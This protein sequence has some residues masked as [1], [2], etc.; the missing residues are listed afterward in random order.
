[1]KCFRYSLIGLLFASS[2]F[3]KD[4][5][6]A[7]ST[8][9][10]PPAGLVLEIKAA[11]PPTNA[12]YRPILVTLVNKGDKPVSL[13]MPGDGSSSGW[14]TPLIGWSVIKKGE[15][16]KH[17][18]E[19]P[20]YKGPRC[21]QMNPLQKSEIFTL[22]PGQSKK[23]EWTS[24]PDQVDKP[25][26]YR[27][28]CYYANNPEIPWHAWRQHDPEAIKLAQQSTKCFLRSNEIEIEVKGK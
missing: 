16:G 14:R 11:G 1:M 5:P 13:V 20:L 22:Q 7:P 12:E 24:I 23:L 6:A 18:N 26:T 9:T 10:V 25:G 2:V 21:K 28:V 8:A 3:A 4:E 15:A 17:P 19:V 27:L